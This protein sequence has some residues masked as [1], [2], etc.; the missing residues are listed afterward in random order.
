MELVE[1]VPGLDIKDL[2]EEGRIVDQ[3]VLYIRFLENK[4]GEEKEKLKEIFQLVLFK[5]NSI[6]NCNT[7]CCTL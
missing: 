4:L 3:T 2:Q 5:N 1:L 6:R 7:L